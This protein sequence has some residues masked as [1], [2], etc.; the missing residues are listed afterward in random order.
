[1]AKDKKPAKKASD[2]FHNIMKASV[3][4]NTKRRFYKGIFQ[5]NQLKEITFVGEQFEGNP[6]SRIRNVA[7]KTF[8]WDYII[9]EATDEVNAKEKIEETVTK[10]KQIK[11]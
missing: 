5:D 6:T 1:M 9:V 2:T 8:V 10:E 11:S 7:S 3:K 4:V